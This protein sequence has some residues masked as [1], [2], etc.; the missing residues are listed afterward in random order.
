M[1][2]VKIIDSNEQARVVEQQV[3]DEEL[4]EVLEEWDEFF[5]GKVAV[6][7]IPEVETVYMAR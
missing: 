4:T 7:A 3:S 1:H 2:Q 6:F 5:D